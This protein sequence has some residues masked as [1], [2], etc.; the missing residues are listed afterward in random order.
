[1]C[2]MWSLTSKT[3]LCEKQQIEV[4]MQQLELTTSMHDII[5][6]TKEDY[7]CQNRAKKYSDNHMN[8][9]QRK[10]FKKTPSF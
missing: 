6:V 1:M 2:S 10:Y 8:C 3:F 9:L 4:K 5:Q 7:D